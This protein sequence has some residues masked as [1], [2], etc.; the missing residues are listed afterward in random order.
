MCVGSGK[1]DGTYGRVTNTDVAALDALGDIDEACVPNGS[2][3]ADSFYAGALGLEA[4]GSAYG[5]NALNVVS[6]GF[7]V[8]SMICGRVLTSELQTPMLPAARPRL[9]SNMHACQ[10]VL[11]VH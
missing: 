6:N 9:T 3:A 1:V 5:L 7:V 2:S 11:E 8:Y 4:I 10:T